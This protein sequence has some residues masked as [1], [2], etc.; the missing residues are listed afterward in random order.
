MPDFTLPDFPGVLPDRWIERAVAAEVITSDLRIRSESIQPASFD[1]HLGETAY[2]LL[3]SFLPNGRPV[4]KGLRQLSMGEIKL[5]DGGAVL[6][7]DRPYLIPLV[8][9]LN[10]P[11]GVRAKTNPKSSTGRVDVFTRVVCDGGYHFDEIPANYSGP[12]YLEVIPRSFAIRIERWM[13]LNQLRL[14]V[15]PTTVNDAETRQA[16]AEHT[17]L[18]DEHG[19][20]V[21]GPA[22]RTREGLFLSL[23]LA[24]SETPVGYKAKRNSLVLDLTVVDHYRPSEFWEPVYPDPGV[25]GLVLEPD[26]FYL[27]MS[28]EGVSIPPGF[29]AEMTA[30]DPTSG[31]LRTHYAGFFDPGFGFRQ[32]GGS[33][34]ALEVRAHDVPF[35]VE[36]GQFVCKLGFERMAEEPTRLYGRQINSNYQGQQGA[37]SK[38][39][40]YP[41]PGEDPQLSLLR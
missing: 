28:A 35:L 8:E 36:H 38:H 22:V 31:E 6:E 14:L 30:Y 11:E 4:E 34:A 9:R 29:A 41:R 20:K 25:G 15:E 32:K 3:C 24:D 12:L 7:R 21:R 39:F 16:H 33:R 17:L 1:L 13:S 27:L 26:A 19:K 10:L 18:Y 40:Q 23:D 37:L 5:N 2:R